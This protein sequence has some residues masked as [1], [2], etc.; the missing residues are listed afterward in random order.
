M[1]FPPPLDNRDLRSWGAALGD[2]CRVP[3][4]GSKRTFARLWTVAER[5]RTSDCRSS[6]KINKDTRPV[7]GARSKFSTR[8]ALGAICLCFY[9]YFHG[10]TREGLGRLTKRW[11]HSWHL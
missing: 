1:L 10:E 6:P 9:E 7:L 8:S 3:G 2:T 5:R 4:A 11:T